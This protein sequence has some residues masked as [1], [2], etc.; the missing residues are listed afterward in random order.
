M[1]N[2]EILIQAARPSPEVNMMDK[3]KF[4]LS[5]VI[6][7]YNYEKFV[8]QAIQSILSVKADSL[9]LIVID[10]GSTDGS[11]AA[12]ERFADKLTYI[13]IDNIGSINAC[14]FG[15]NHS[16]GKFIHFLDAD[17]YVDSVAFSRLISLLNDKVSKVQ[18][19]L[20]PVNESGEVIGMPFP[21]LNSNLTSGDL[22]E[23]INRKGYYSTPPT[24]GN[25]YRRDVYQ[26]VGN[27][28][29][30][31]GIDGVAYLVAPFAGE[32][33]SIDQPVGFYRHHASNS[34][35]FANFNITTLKRDEEIFLRRLDHLNEILLTLDSSK[36]KFQKKMTYFAILEKRI[37]S[38]VLAG[39]RPRFGLIREYL[40]AVMR[41]RESKEWI[42]RLCYLVTLSVFPNNLAQKLAK[43]RLNHSSQ[44]NLRQ[45]L[46][47]IF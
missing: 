32:V 6:T 44:S 25:I 16:S 21:K 4:L 40:W 7:C 39:Q 30:D 15:F 17:D 13:R 20:N 8:G 43:F 19:M 33:I 45:A 5:V 10:D 26:I 38:V 9:E 42:K 3:S 12:I 11:A 27:L 37:T 18:F 28:D 31:K 22:I 34:S 1:R 47:R 24:S 2:L 46:K 23:Q 35:G 14:L 41:E 29:Y 36:Y